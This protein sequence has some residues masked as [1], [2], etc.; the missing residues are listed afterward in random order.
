MNLDDSIKQPFS[1]DSF[2]FNEAHWEQAR[3]LLDADSAKRAYWRKVYWIGLALSLLIV[4]VGISAYHF[5]D[6]KV[7]KGMS[8]TNNFELAATLL[9]RDND[10]LYNTQTKDE[11]L[12]NNPT[13]N[14][15]N[16]SLQPINTAETK[17]FNHKKIKDASLDSNSKGIIDQSIKSKPK[18]Y[19]TIKEESG[20]KDFQSRQHGNL[21]K[22]VRVPDEGTMDQLA[23]NF[24]S[25][26]D[27]P[28]EI[29]RISRV[30]QQGIIESNYESASGGLLLKSVARKPSWYLGTEFVAF[31]TV[32]RE[33]SEFQYYGFSAGLAYQYPIGDR[34][35]AEIGGRF[36]ARMGDFT[37]SQKSPQ[38]DFDFGPRNNA[39]LLRPTAVYSAQVPL[40]VGIDKERFQ[41][42]G[43][44]VP[45]FLLGVRGTYE[46]ERELFPWEEVASTPRIEQL[47]NGWLDN[48]GFKSFAFAYVLKYQHKINSNLQVGGGLWYRSGDWVG[49]DYG[50][51]IDP[52]TQEWVNTPHE[53]RDKLRRNWSLSF[54]IRYRW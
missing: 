39:H 32:S 15:Q 51:F 13:K 42:M 1:P 17:A 22:S 40:Y 9:E 50:R 41:L 28:E 38:L 11:I 37:P 18:G 16:Q 12:V 25:S 46:F 19:F 36:A 23:L 20:N 5:L 7:G 27:L 29:S 14:P 35:F 3:V 52:A 54:E 26:L 45:S 31:P 49:E 21:E 24:L 6:R 4:I 47:S 53:Y 8:N 44:V 34:F 10:A 2:E 48:S 30:E 43:G 33:R